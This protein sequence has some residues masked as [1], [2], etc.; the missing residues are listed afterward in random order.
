MIKEIERKVRH[1]AITTYEENIVKIP[2]ESW[3]TPQVVHYGTGSTQKE[4]FR[5]VCDLFDFTGK[6]ILDIGCG[7]GHFYKYLMG[8]GVKDFGY[9][10]IDV[11][12]TLLK[13]A[14]DHC[15]GANFREV[16]WPFEAEKVTEEID[17]AVLVRVF[18]I[19]FAQL[20][21]KERRT[22]FSYFIEEVMELVKESFVF[23]LLAGT[24]RVISELP[25]GYDLG[26]NC[27]I[28]QPASTGTYVRLDWKE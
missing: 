6:R 22:F 4:H 18:E 19:G 13:L 24:R 27:H 28:I 7:V 26:W 9:L 3:Y 17:V 20:F 16:L 25:M 1:C 10:G 5:T 2:E 11:C 21:E 15:P 12:P 14:T 8:E 23:Q